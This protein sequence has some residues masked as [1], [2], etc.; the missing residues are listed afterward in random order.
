M[1]SYGIGYAVG[2]AALFKAAPVLAVE[3]GERGVRAYNVHPGFVATERMAL[4][5]AE[6]EGLD[7]SKAA[8]PEV[9]GAVVAWLA[10]DPAD[11]PPNGSLVESQPFCAEHRLVEGWPPGDG[12]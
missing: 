5:A 8:P 6:Q 3:L 10:D 1:G 9:C 12:A 7:L 2:K 4:H 11:P